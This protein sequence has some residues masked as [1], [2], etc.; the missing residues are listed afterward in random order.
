MAGR[1]DGA[2]SLA[3]VVVGGVALA[4]ALAL[5]VAQGLGTPEISLPEAG[6]RLAVASGGG[7]ARLAV[8]VARCRGERVTGVELRRP[9]GVPLWRILSDDGSIDDRYVV[10]ADPAPLGFDVAVPLEGP[11]PAGPLVVAAN[12]A[13]QGG[14]GLGD[15]AGFDPRAVPE[16]GAL[17]QGEVIPGDEAA[18]QALA[19]AVCPEPEGLGTWTLVLD[20]VG[21]V[22][23]VGYGLVVVRWWQGRR[24]TW[25]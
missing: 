10:G 21:V 9:D 15:E 20:A 13:R 22:L 24:G 11:L 19:R 12:L 4:A 8:V 23:V 2:P 6:R 16:E 14:A 5:I 3:A 17:Y 7:P 1:V 25:G 18:Q